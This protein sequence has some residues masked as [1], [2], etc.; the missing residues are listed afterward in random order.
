VLDGVTETDLGGL[1]AARATAREVAW[2]ARGEVTGTVL[3]PI[4]VAGRDL[5]DQAG[6]PVL[7][8]DLDAT[9]VMAHSEK[10]N[11][12][13]TFKHTWGYHP[14]LAFCDNTNEALAGTLR[15][16]NAG[17]N[18]AADHLTV[19]D[20]ALRQISDDYRY[21]YP[22]GIRSDGAGSSQA[23]LAHIGGL[24][25]SLVAA[26]FSVGW[27]I[28]DRERDAIRALPARAWTPAIDANSDPR[29][30]AD[31]AELTRLLPATTLAKYPAGCGSSCGAA[32]PPRRATRPVRCPATARPGATRED[33]LRPHCLLSAR[34]RPRPRRRPATRPTSGAASSGCGRFGSIR[35][36]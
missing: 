17:S 5:V 36:A 11:A 18:T 10:E 25:E 14:L 30:G 4:S 15:A 19:G 9:I 12:A 27:A 3:P 13:A 21:R 8:I 32:P 31:V 20:A 29:E 34:R 7:V 16:G 24:E 35:S 22:I 33:A 23:L 28:T 1:A 26:D 6:R 2:L